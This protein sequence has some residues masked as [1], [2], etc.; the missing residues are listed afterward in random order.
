[1]N[2]KNEHHQIKDI[3]FAETMA[4]A[5][6]PHREDALQATER[7]KRAGD[8]A[9]QLSEVGAEKLPIKRT[10]FEQAEQSSRAFSDDFI[11]TAIGA[12]YSTNFEVGGTNY[13][14]TKGY[15]DKVEST[16]GDLEVTANPNRIA[17]LYA[18]TTRM[19]KRNLK[20]QHI[21][22][23]DNT[24]RTAELRQRVVALKDEFM[25]KIDDDLE[26]VPAQI[27]DWCEGSTNNYPVAECEYK[28]RMN[29]DGQDIL[30]LDTAASRKVRPN[31][32]IQRHLSGTFVM[33]YSNQRVTEKLT[34]NAEEASKRIYLN[35]DA[36]STPEIFEQ[37]FHAANDKGLSLQ[38]KMF[39][40]APEMAVAHRTT[41]DGQAK[42]LRGDGIVIYATDSEADEVLGSV[43]EIAD[44]N[45]NAFV[46]RRT[47]RVPTY[48][49]DGI[50][51]GAETTTEQGGSLTSHRAGV[52]NE[53]ATE[54]RELGLEGDQAHRRFREL[55]RQKAIESGINPDN[56]AF[57][58]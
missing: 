42:P 2:K 15:L 49:A 28:S 6:R 17:D 5:E 39:Q 35:P 34:G 47:S 41:K 16:L 51:V 36:E 52:V 56:L 50:A 10:S 9:L 3:A 44:N 57:N 26:T 48:I 7:A 55:F 1:M 18:A 14:S 8:A 33:A 54:V 23:L 27:I 38:L 19:I 24:E 37:V 21:R 20:L 43:L 31:F 46:G 40:R 45:P 29:F 53:V 58:L 13:I 22:Y 30:D 32:R 4:Y 25:S 11:D 12:V